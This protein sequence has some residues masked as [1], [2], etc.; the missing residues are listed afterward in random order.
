MIKKTDFFNFFAIIVAYLGL[1]LQNLTSLP[2]FGDEAIYIRWSQIIKSVETLRFIPQTDGKQPLFMWLVV[3]FFKVIADPVVAARIVS[4]LAGL[5]T[6]LIIYLTL[7]IIFKIKPFNCLVAGLVYLFI[8]FTF[9]FDRLALPDNL[10]AFFGVL[11]LLFSLLLA[12]YP[13]LDLALILGGI[14]GSAWLTKSPAIYFILLSLGTFVFINYS[15]PKLFIL[16]L[17]SAAISW[18]IYNILRLGP[19]FTQL[20]IRNKDYIWSLNDIIKHP[21]DP[22]LPHLSDTVTII[23]RYISWPIFGLILV[24]LVYSFSKKKFNRYLLLVIFWCLL[25]LIASLAI[26]KVFTARYILFCLPP[27]FIAAGYFISQLP[28]K[29]YFL[30]PILLIPNFIFIYQLS[31]K[32]FSVTLPAT[33][34]GYVKDWTSGWGIKSVSEYLINRSTQANVIVGTEGAFGTLPDGLQIYTNN[35]PRL[36]VFGVGLGLTKVPE[37][38][39][40]A[41]R[42]G[43]EVYLLANRSRLQLDSDQNTLLVLVSSTP[44]PDNDALL[45]YRLQ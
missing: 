22:F 28:A 12:K 19:Q 25:P 4:V 34:A 17:I 18:G 14:L 44:K 13:R 10:L 6:T 30:L 9:F 29:T 23:S 40:D 8:P 1:R 42:H 2:V 39:L 38:L 15:R 33:E 24:A 37:K 27:F 31:T 3:P 36:T 16:S 43:D 41:R 21:L 32:P 26:A 7:R 20:A 35:I 5:G 45:L 11:S